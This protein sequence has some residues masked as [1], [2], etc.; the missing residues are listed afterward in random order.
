MSIHVTHCLTKNS[1]GVPQG[2]GR[3]AR[4]EGLASDVLKK[5]VN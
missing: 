3:L 1:L 2:I 4:T 5:G